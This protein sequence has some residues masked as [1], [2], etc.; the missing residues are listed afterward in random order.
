MNEIEEH[1]KMCG[2]R[3]TKCKICNKNMTY[4][5]L[6]NHLKEFHNLNKYE[7]DNLQI[8]NKNSYNLFNEK[9]NGNLNDVDL[10]KMS[11]DEQLAYAIS[12]SQNQDIIKNNL[13]NLKNEDSK[14][15]DKKTENEKINKTDDNV[16]RKQTDDS[17]DI[18]FDDVENE[19]EK[20]YYEEEA[21]EYQ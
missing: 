1:E 18:N 8:S 20:Y 6:K 5:Q 16:L 4:I 17:L 14:N 3:S 9:L 15:I 12:L 13:G 7:Y 2:A 11:S 19:M 10:A 21:K